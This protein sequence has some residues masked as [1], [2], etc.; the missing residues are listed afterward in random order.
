DGSKLAGKK[1]LT[2][3]G[4]L[5]WPPAPATSVDVI[6]NWQHDNPPG[7]AFKSGVIPTS[8]GDTDPFAPAE[9]NRGRALGVDRTV[10]GVTAIVEHEF[11]QAWS[12]TSITGWREYGAL[13]NFDA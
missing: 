4:S 6:V 10:D 12:L 3:R 5:R 11:N 1:P 7:T 9:L 8:R 13:E 2:M